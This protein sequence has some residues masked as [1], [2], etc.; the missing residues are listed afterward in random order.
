MF[1]GEMCWSFQPCQSSS[2]PPLRWKVAQVRVHR[3]HVGRRR[4]HRLPER[5]HRELQVGQLVVRVRVVRVGQVAQVGQREVLTGHRLPWARRHEQG[6]LEL[7]APLVGDLR[8]EPPA[9]ARPPRRRG[10]CRTTA[11]SAARQARRRVLPGRAQQRR[12]IEV[13]EPRVVDQPVRQRRR[14][15]RRPRATA[16]WISG[17]L[18][19]SRMELPRVLVGQDVPGVVEG[20]LDGHVVGRR[21]GGDAVEVIRVALRLH[22]R[23]AAAVGAAGEVRVGRRGGRRT[24]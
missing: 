15:R 20:V 23:L 22:Q 11:A 18:P 8:L 2:L 21:A 24:P 7:R 17:S 5:R 3:G 9:R 6:P 13:A 1:C 16:A 19:A 12:R 4:Q 14:S 10:V